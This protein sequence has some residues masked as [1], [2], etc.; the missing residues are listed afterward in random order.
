EASVDENNEGNMSMI[1]VEWLEHITE[2]HPIGWFDQPPVSATSAYY[3]IVHFS[4]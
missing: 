2:F 3:Y 1:W 4:S